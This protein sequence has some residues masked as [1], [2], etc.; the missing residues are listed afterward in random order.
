MKYFDG[1]RPEGV[2]ITPQ[3]MAH[4]FHE[5]LSTRPEG[6]ADAPIKAFLYFNALSIIDYLKGAPVF[7]GLVGA[8]DGH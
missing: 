7:H 6:V 1:E 3:G 4:K 2:E 5:A 8:D